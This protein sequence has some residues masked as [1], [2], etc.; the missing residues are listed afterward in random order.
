MIKVVNILIRITLLGISICLPVY[1][2]WILLL[3]N[4]QSYLL[5][6]IVYRLSLCEY[7]WHHTRIQIMNLINTFILCL[8]ATYY[9][10]NNIICVANGRTEEQLKTID[11]KYKS[12]FLLFIVVLDDLIFIIYNIYIWYIFLISTRIGWNKKGW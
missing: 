5:Y 7:E 11:S 9:L 4:G 12:L 6:R 10:L 2:F 1:V 8:T 3:C